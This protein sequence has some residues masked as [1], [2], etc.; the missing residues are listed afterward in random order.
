MI[1]PSSCNFI[2]KGACPEEIEMVQDILNSYIEYKVNPGK[3][4][5]FESSDDSLDSDNTWMIDLSDD[6]MLKMKHMSFL[7]DR[8]CRILY[9]KEDR[10]RMIEQ[11]VLMVSGMREIDVDY[12]ETLPLLEKTCRFICTDDLNEDLLPKVISIVKEMK[13]AAREKSVNDHDFLIQLCDCDLFYAG[14][15]FDAV[16][17]IEDSDD[18]LLYNQLILY[19]S[20]AGYKGTDSEYGIASIV[21][22]AFWFC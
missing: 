7:S 1:R 13:K 21:A 3:A 20:S 4:M 10:T 18:F 14:E 2:L 9:E 16:D 8:E 11:M 22:P 19:R 17:G 15:I 6:G 12:A 5:S